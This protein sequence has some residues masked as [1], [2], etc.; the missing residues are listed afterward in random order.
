MAFATDLATTVRG[1]ICCRSF[2]LDSSRRQ[3]RA[4]DGATPRQVMDVD[5]RRRSNAKFASF[6]YTSMPSISSSTSPL[7]SPACLMEV[8][9]EIDPFRLRAKAWL[10][11]RRKGPKVDQNSARGTARQQQDVPTCYTEQ[12]TLN[13]HKKGK[14]TWPDCLL[15][16]TSPP[17]HQSS[18]PFQTEIQAH[19]HRVQLFCQCSGLLREA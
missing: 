5:A 3:S 13:K 6:L 18:R 15:Q 17:T 7:Q 2:L 8:G 11:K 19:S 10:G 14:R 9:R 16:Q 1:S 4:V 12:E